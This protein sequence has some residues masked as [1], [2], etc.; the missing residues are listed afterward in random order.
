M[1]VC[2]FLYSNGGWGKIM[3]KLTTLPRI[4]IRVVCRLTQLL[5]AATTVELRSHVTSNY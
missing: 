5:I 2:F 1:C 3:V 4:L